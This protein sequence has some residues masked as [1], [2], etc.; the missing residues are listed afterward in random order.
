MNTSSKD[1]KN[2]DF[3]LQK[4]KFRIDSN[5]D[6]MFSLLMD[7]NCGILFQSDGNSL[8]TTDAT[9]TEV[10][11]RTLI[12]NSDIPAKIIHAINGDIVLDAKQGD[13]VL[14]GMNIR[15]EGIDGLGGEVTINSS[16][17]VQISAPIVN[18]QS[19]KCTITGV[20]STSIAGGSSETLGE[21][22]ND[23]STGTDF[24][25]ASFF[26]KILSAIQRFKKFFD[27]ICG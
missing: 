17:I 8:F 3:L 25:Q 1:L 14:R 27:S 16:K 6:Y 2:F 20:V 24:I 9:S 4:H 21:I 23:H 22:A 5:S 18:T 11:G 19:D 12:P 7:N 26:G 13:I 15:I 10:V